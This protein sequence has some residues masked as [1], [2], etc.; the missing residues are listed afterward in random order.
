MSNEIFYSQVNKSLQDELNA[1]GNAGFSRTTDALNYMLTKIGNVEVTAYS[2]Q[3]YETALHTLGGREVTTDPYVAGKKTGFLSTP[4]WK[5]TDQF[6]KESSAVDNSFRTP[7]FITS[8]DIQLNDHSFG[9]LNSAVI[10]IIIPNPGRDLGF[11]E[12][13]FARPGRATRMT[14]AH[15]NTALANKKETL[16]K[17]PAPAGFETVVQEIENKNTA[18]KKPA[19]N[20]VV[21]DGLVISFDYAYQSDGTVALTIYLRGKSDV[22]TDVSMYISDKSKNDNTN[23][24][25]STTFYKELYTEVDTMISESVNPK[26]QVKSAYGYAGSVPGKMV[27]TNDYSVIAHT[28]WNKNQQRYV[29][30]AYLISTINKLIISKYSSISP[31][32]LIYCSDTIC[33]SSKFDNIVSADPTNIWLYKSDEYGVSND[34]TPR[35]WSSKL[36]TL[37]NTTPIG[38]YQD[39]KIGYPSRILLN[40]NLIESIYNSIQTDKDD[41]VVSKFLSELG[42][43]I[44]NA[45]GGAVNMKL[46]TYADTIMLYYDANYLGDI[47]G[48]TPYSVPMFANH[49]SGSI[50]RD[51][52]IESKLP[53]NAQA[54]MYTINQSSVIS[55]EMIAPY[56][57]FMYN[58]EIITRDFTTKTETRSSNVSKETQKT[59]ETRYKEFYE[60]YKKELVTAK[61]NFNLTN[62]QSKIALETALKKYVQYPTDNIN[63]SAVMQ[64]P[65]YPVDVTFTIDGVN[66][67]K[68]GDA[69]EFK[70]LPPRYKKDTTFSII[71]I[72]HNINNSGDWTTKIKCIMRPKF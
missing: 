8:A 10:S 2:D 23:E 18:P 50:V 58:N 59:Y 49:E 36:T 1:R 7:P 66:G 69:L 51:F 13:V 12:S 68:F 17:D 33:F 45:T 40:L 5:T 4:T 21:F 34:K 53:Q 32:A 44:Y 56:M 30:L 24:T 70:A 41:F 63:K 26:V 9:L 15:P 28:D 61:Q 19:L 39:D 3:K 29:S 62:A 54:L 27:G 11:I 55:E 35:S 57:S 65:I 25:Q 31:D 46:V 67:F 48:V 43:Q 16:E 60:K 22:F 52:T 71:S 14:I 37:K 42:K 6:G 64:S 72:T 47:H 20:Q 38:P